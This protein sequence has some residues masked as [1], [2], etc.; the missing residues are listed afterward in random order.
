MIFCVRHTAHINVVSSMPVL[1]CT[2]DVCTVVHILVHRS[3]IMRA[4]HFKGVAC[5]HCR[6]QKGLLW[7]P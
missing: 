3:Y 6:K 2:V 1:H 7:K 4:L 5:F